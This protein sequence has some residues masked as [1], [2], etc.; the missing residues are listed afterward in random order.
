MREKCRILWS[1][2]GG[3][4]REEFTVYVYRNILYIVII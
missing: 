3:E 1:S 4:S 2:V